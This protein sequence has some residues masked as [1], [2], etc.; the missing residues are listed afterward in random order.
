ML[1]S[2]PNAFGDTATNMAIDSA[3]LESIPEGLAAFR[4]YGWLEPAATFG[5]SQ[6]YTEVANTTG[7]DLALCRRLTGGGIVDHRNDWTYALVLHSSLPCATTPATALYQQIH[8]AIRATLNA[9]QIDSHLAPC[10]RKC[11][12]TANTRS[13]APS[14]CFVTPAAND[15]LRADGQKIA[16]AAMKRNRHGLLIQGSLDRGALPETFNYA[17]FQQQLIEQLAT[18]LGLP[19]GQLEDIRP[20]FN[21]ERIQREK[22][23]FTS[24]AWNLRR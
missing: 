23:R 6:T 4:H 18:E 24:E 22:E 1:I 8:T 14:Q 16:G 20:L 2:L 7:N 21:S 11:S 3:L 9:F 15:V 19:T 13:D 12:E 10:P 17:T 5:Y